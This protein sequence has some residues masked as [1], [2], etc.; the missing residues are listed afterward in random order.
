M[1]NACKDLDRKPE[2]KGPLGGLCADGR[3]LLIQILRKSF[4]NV[5]TGFVWLRM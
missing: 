1:R 4:G 2:R 3:I 5:C